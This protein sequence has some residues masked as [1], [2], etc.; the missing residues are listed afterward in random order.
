METLSL[1]LEGNA[2]EVFCFWL[3]EKH[4]GLC[5]DQGKNVTLVA[6]LRRE[7]QK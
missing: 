2:T 1:Q 5:A 7:Q 4:T 6:Y 3:P